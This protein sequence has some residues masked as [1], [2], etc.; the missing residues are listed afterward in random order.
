MYNIFISYA[1]QHLTWATHL[2]GS[3]AAPGV[4]VYVADTDLP[5]GA[6]LSAEISRVIKE[7]DLFLI[8]WSEAARSSQYVNKEI[9]TAKTAGKPIIPIQLEP[10][11]P[12]PVELG[13]IKYLDVA[14]DPAVQMEWL[15]AEV[16][17]R[18][19]SK[20][21]STFVGGALIAFL[22]WAFLTSGAK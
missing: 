14:K 7:T 15:K 2:R 12:L 18:A 9:F 10:G 6:S 20:A 13:D 8:L 16:N 11:V 5:P 3:L 4:A 1:Q 21:T 19:Q 22:G 17:R